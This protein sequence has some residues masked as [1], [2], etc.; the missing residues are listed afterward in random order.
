[1]NQETTEPSFADL[2]QESS[3]KSL[4]RL[5]PG[6]KITATIVGH[7]GNSVF[8]DVGGKNEGILESSELMNKEGELSAT[9][10]DKVE[11]YFLKSTGGAQ[12]FT[13]K[14]GGGKNTTHLEEAWRNAIPVEGLV[15]EEIKGGFDITL[16]G[17]VRAFCPFSQMGLHRVDD[18][19]AEYTG[20]HMTFLITRFEENGR[21]IVVSARALLEQEREQQKEAL[22]ESLVEGGT[23]H[24]TISSI[25][26]FGAFVDIGG[27]DGLIPI[28]EIGWS[29]VED[30]KEHL[31]VG[32]EVTAV[33]KKLDWK[34]GRITLSLKETLP[35]PWD[36]ARENFTEGSTHSGIV[37]RLTT[38]GAFVTLAPGVDGL[39]HISKLG[40][41]RR[42]NHP[43][44]VLE[45]GQEIEVKIEGID[46]ETR[47]IS[48]APTD[49]VS[50]ESEETA[51]KD[52]YKKFTSKNK[53]VKK[54]E[55]A[56]G[57]LGALLQEKLKN[58]SK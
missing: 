46:N 49:Y 35:N 34:A 28:S 1:M 17:S 58:L 55:E 25:R 7:S 2:F 18:A 54:Q 42:I 9:I 45:E 15:K 22:Q 50:S 51:E 3:S 5:E 20:R 8:L 14:L 40:G 37:A 12:L 31:T 19:G 43:R 38:F 57:S 13:I 26:D 29:R 4:R 33:I 53:P 48:L 27:V 41:G 39:I 10:G 32:Q 36:M 52:E 21:N 56:V 6:Q 11:V 30:I 44:E 23:V 16:G 24:G 47:K